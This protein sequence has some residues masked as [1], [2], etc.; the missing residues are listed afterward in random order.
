[1]P[2][3]VDGERT[4]TGRGE[5]YTFTI[6]HKPAPGFEVAALYVFAYVSLQDG[7][8]VLA[9]ICGPD[10]LQTRIGDRVELVGSAEP[11]VT[12]AL[13]FAREAGQ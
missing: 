2:E 8:T 3:R 10:H 4:L 13:R 12:G 9:N 11:G 1:L 6:V 5:V 7:P